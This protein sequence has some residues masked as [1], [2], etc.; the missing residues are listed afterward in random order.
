MI[1][2]KLGILQ[3]QLP[4]LP[5]YIFKLDK[6][7][8][9]ERKSHA[10]DY[11]N[12]V[13]VFKG[14]APGIG[15]KRLVGQDES[16]IHTSLD[17]Y[18][19]SENQG[20]N[21]PA[22]VAFDR[23]VL[24]FYA[25]FQEA[26]HERREEKYRIRRVNIYFYLE[27]DSVHVSEP[28]TV[29]SG[30]PQGTLI[31]RHR[32]PKPNSKI[33]QHYIVSDFNIGHQVTFYSRTFMIVGCDEFT[34]EFLSSIQI[35]VPDN[36]EF[37]ADPYETQRNELLGRMKA[38]RPSIPNFS[39]KKF[40]END[41]RV[42]RFYCVWDDTNSVFGDLRHMVVHYFLSDD[43]IE[44]RESIPAN[45][46]RESNALFLRRCKLPK[47]PHMK[48]VNADSG[49]ENS[50]DYFTERDFM[51]GG[52]LHLYGRPFVICDCDEFTKSFYRENY[53]VSEFDPVKIDLYD[54]DA[55]VLPFFD[56]HT[57]A[58]RAENSNGSTAEPNVTLIGN[59]PSHKKDFKKL[60]LYDGVK[61]RYLACLKSN[62]QVDRDRKFVITYHL[63]DDTIS[64]FEP[65]SRNSG[66]IGG[67]FLEQRRIKKPI[68]SKFYESS[69]FSIGADLIF[70]NHHFVVIGADDYAIKFMDVNP[71]LFPAHKA[72]LT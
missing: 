1:D 59:E 24:R 60:I 51:I 62:K 42:L 49:V 15:G 56:A 4:L 35:T 21:V 48:K 30:I 29:N 37:P 50:N 54:E 16:K 14:N 65:C 19:H 17:I 34:R 20:E 58:L 31:R 12:G 41:R 5:G 53:G 13:A 26:V 6:A 27:D 11:C 55:G 46:G 18:P 40:L 39:L 63:A 36:G 64:V 57:A 33:D 70:Y 28:K 22:W 52:V 72:K 3:G 47:R 44:I 68:T 61:L 8:S 45:S 2:Q 7:Q 43:T 10:F 38:T 66:I 32:I 67:K 23:K 69:D 71:E 25:Y 9:N